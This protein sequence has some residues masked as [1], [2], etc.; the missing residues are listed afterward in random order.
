MAWLGRSVPLSRRRSWVNEGITE[1]GRRELE[2]LGSRGGGKS[3]GQIGH[4]C[5]E[6][7]TE[8]VRKKGDSTQRKEPPERS[9]G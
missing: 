9:S 7:V 4:E 5:G 2:W 1:A 3:D 8:G 6:G